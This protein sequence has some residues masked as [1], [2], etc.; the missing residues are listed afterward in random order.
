[1]C[2]KKKKEIKESNKTYEANVS[3][4]AKRS[5]ERPTKHECIDSPGIRLVHVIER[6]IHI[7]H[8]EYVCAY[9]NVLIDH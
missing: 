7:L 3:T 1:M 8:T 6:Q 9:V 2:L 5:N 4:L